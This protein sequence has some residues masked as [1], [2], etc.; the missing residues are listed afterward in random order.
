MLRALDASA[1]RR[2]AELALA[3]L[4]AE[5]EAIDR[6]NVYP[7]A[8]GDTGTNLLQTAR[9]GAAE[10]VRRDP[11]GAGAALDAWAVGALGGARGNSGVLLSQVLRGL[12]EAVGAAEEIDGPLLRAA[13]AGAEAR[14]VRAV[15]EPVEGTLLT[16]LRAAAAAPE[17][18]PLP[19]VVRAA[20]GAASAEL[21]ATPRRLPV[22]AEA[23]VVDAG[24]RGLLV[25]LDALHAVVHDGVRLAAAPPDP[26][27]S[28]LR[29]DSGYD[30]EV[31]YLLA[32][33][34][35]DRIEPLR[36]ELLGL[37]DCVSVVDDGGGTWAVHVH[38][39]DIGGAI[40]A[41]IRTGRVSRIKV[42]RFADQVPDGFA[43]TAAVL[44]CVPGAELGALFA[45]EG[46]DVFG[47][48]RDSA[49]ELHAAIAG[50][51]AAH[52]VVLLNGAECVAGVAARA[53]RRAIRAGQDVVV[54]PTSSPVQGLAAL[55]VHDPDRRR[56]EDQVAMAEAA[57][58]TRRGELRIAESEALTWVGRCRPGDVLGLIDGEVVLIGAEVPR[59]AVELVD[60]MLTSGGELVTALVAATA[61]DLP[62]SLGE[63]LRRTHPEVEL[64]C[65]PI[66]GN[67]PL[68]LLGVE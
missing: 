63:H 35:A 6:I 25:L 28:P 33:P 29:H 1:V 18:G 47:G 65:F 30:Y 5:R 40:E 64:T 46:A 48:R 12:A 51:R 44:A 54:V 23:G 55:A 13:L 16:V 31:M 14:A 27:V 52:V 19:A 11:A 49:E 43:R 50:T 66:G 22:L 38:C 56:A 39:D 3:A 10:L 4:T 36:A 59:A 7:V 42:E 57:A 9:A 68:L 8:D 32:E 34:D 41:G 67:A 45:A 53:A 60:R 26:P 58:A 2:W 21:A 20:T 15:A 61:G 62:E 17:D 37:G 24:G